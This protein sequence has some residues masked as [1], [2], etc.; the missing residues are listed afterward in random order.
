MKGGLDAATYDAYVAFVGKIVYPIF[1]QVGWDAKEGDDDN[2]KKLRATLVSNVA[3]YCAKTPEVAAEAK[4]RCAAFLADPSD[5][6]VLD[7]NIRAAVFKI[8]MQAEGFGEL[9][10]QLVAV[11]NGP[12]DV[13]MKKDIYAGLCSAP[14]AELA[15]RTLEW[16]LTDEVRSQDMIYVPMSVAAGYKDGGDMVW[17]WTL[18]EYERIYARLGATSMMLFSHVVRISG[19]GFMTEA[20]GEEVMAYWKSKPIF[21]QV[22]RAVQQTV[23]GII[24]N[25]KFVDRMR[26]TD[27]KS[28]DF[29]TAAATRV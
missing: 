23:E 20:K 21:S 14:T 22:A 25:A 4:R 5:P 2:K 24:A 1:A 10:E 28:P 6:Q 17:D 11:H 16:C 12:S 8:A 29:W 26:S 18:K 27:L 13:A 19:S 15:A 7:A 9:Y 3:K